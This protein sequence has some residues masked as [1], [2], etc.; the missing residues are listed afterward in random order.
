MTE[1]DAKKVLNKASAVLL[2]AQGAHDV[3]Y[4]R[5]TKKEGFRLLIS[6]AGFDHRFRFDD[7]LIIDM[8][9]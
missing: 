9:L 5:I 7:V 8:P 1:K 6:T 2:V 3:E 4:V